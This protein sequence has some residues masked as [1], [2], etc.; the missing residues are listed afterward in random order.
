M[1][2]AYP[3]LLLLIIPLAGLIIYAFKRRKPTVIIS[4]IKPFSSVAGAGRASLF[5]N[6]PLL[7]YSAAT[8]I[9]IVAAARPQRGIE[10]LMQRAEGI[11]IMLILDVSPSMAAYDIPEKYTTGKE[12]ANAINA[13]KIK[14]RIAIAKEEIKKFIENRPNDRLGLVAFST[15]PFAACPPTLDHGWLFAH[16]ERLDAGSLGEQTGI[17]SPI[18]S[19]V[20][21]LRNCESKRRVA[22]LFTDG[23]NNVNAQITPIQAAKLAKTFDITIYTIGIGSRRS[24]VVQDGFFGKQLIPLQDEFDEKLLK[25]IADT[26]GGRYFTAADEEGLKKTMDEIDK[27]EKT[28]VEQPR[29]VDYRELAQ[30][31]II[32][33]LIL[34][35]AGFILSATWFMKVP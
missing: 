11:D 32:T 29:F 27:L 20:N 5:S 6:L 4:S 26:T 28:S 10:E 33:A 24:Y 21:R 14:N 3:W 22:V 8:A 1:T 9:L 23:R 15:L 7:L 31:L 19:A 35:L 16:L 25:D 12:V 18:S 13:G 17:A 2:F 34:I 30:P